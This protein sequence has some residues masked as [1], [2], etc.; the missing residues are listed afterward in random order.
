MS[1]AGQTL[2]HLWHRPLGMA[3]ESLRHGGPLAQLRTARGRSAMIAAAATLPASPARP[4]A[5]RPL[6]F[7]TGRRFA[8]QTAFC[9]HSLARRSGVSFAPEFYDDGSLDAPSRDLLLR[10]A[11][12]GRIHDSATLRARL[13]EFLPV[14]RFP[15]LR[16]RWERYPH[17]RKIIDVH[18]GREGWR[19]VLDSDL[20]FWREPRF[21]LDWLAAPDRPLHAVDCEENYGYPRLVLEKLA[22]LPVPRLVNV[23]LCALRSDAIDWEF[24]EHA[25]AS[26]I[27]AH[28]TSYYLEQALVALLVARASGHRAIAP[29]EDYVTY[30]SPAEIARPAAVMHHYVDLSRDAYHRHAWRLCLS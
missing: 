8:Y 15:S 20:L 2:Y 28:G 12:Q 11:P 29:A 26:L 16:D 6:H 27:R 10:I 25:S 24:L 17:I 21:L 13:D 1:L 14:A 7:L 30:P 22:G 5:P 19:L 23:G 18:L 4:G 9:L 3:R